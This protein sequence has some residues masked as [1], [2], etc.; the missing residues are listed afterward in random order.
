MH[1]RMIRLVNLCSLVAL[2][3]AAC[4][5]SG[6][7]QANARNE[8]MSEDIAQLVG[9]WEKLTR[10]ACSE[11]YPDSIQFQKG[12][13]YFGQ[14]DPPGTFTLWDVG[15]YAMSSPRQI[16]ISLANDASVT[17]GFSL[18]NDVITFVDPDE[19]E[20]KYRKVK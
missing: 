2:T 20:F 13:L 19:C 5:G 18:S 10:S 8:F 4:V 7:T 1:F 6:P 3:F 17:Y 15:T 12:G 11:V 16:T 9:R 14:K